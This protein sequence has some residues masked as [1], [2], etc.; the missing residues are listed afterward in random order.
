MADLTRSE[1]LKVLAGIPFKR[2]ANRLVNL[3]GVNLSGVDLSRL[4]LRWVDFTDADLTS[5]KLIGCQLDGTRLVGAD[6]SCANLDNSTAECFEPLNIYLAKFISA[7]IRDVLWPGVE[8][9]AADFTCCTIHNSDFEQG[10]FPRARFRQAKWAGGS[11][12]EARLG[13]NDWTDA[14]VA[15]GDWSELIILPGS[16]PPPFHFI[17]IAN[18]AAVAAA[19]E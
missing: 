12:H 9:E 3:A 6:L 11:M 4:D 18:T 13:D 16:T 2:S 5:A 10:D 1:L 8:A 15:G 17:T 7:S 19:Q 14:E